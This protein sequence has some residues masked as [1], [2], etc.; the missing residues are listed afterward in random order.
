MEQCCLYEEL[1]YND[2]H[3]FFFESNIEVL[4]YHLHSM[5]IVIFHVT[6]IKYG[7]QELFPEIFFSITFDLFVENPVNS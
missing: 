5:K 6:R 1:L 7:L 4:N 2:L 3:K